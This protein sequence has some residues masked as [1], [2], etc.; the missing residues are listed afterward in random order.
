MTEERTD[1]L[2]R[3]LGYPR[4]QS[5]LPPLIHAAIH[6]IASQGTVRVGILSRDRVAWAIKELRKWSIR[7]PWFTNPNDWLKQIIIEDAEAFEILAMSIQLEFIVDGKPRCWTG[8]GSYI[9]HAK[10]AWLRSDHPAADTIMRNL[11]S[12]RP[13]LIV[14][15]NLGFEYAPFENLLQK[16]HEDDKEST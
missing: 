4:D 6:A 10:D 1:S 7:K 13:P 2:G 16:I 15:I 9:D 14:T 5:E 11:M 3:F 8:Y 12:K